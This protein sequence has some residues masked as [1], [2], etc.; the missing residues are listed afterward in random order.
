MDFSD[1]IPK[2]GDKQNLSFNDL[3]PVERNM[4]MSAPTSPADAPDT[5]RAQVDRERAE[6][7]FNNPAL[8]ERQKMGIARRMMQ[9]LSQGTTDEAIAAL[10]TPL[11]MIKRGTLNPIKG[12]EYAKAQEDAALDE[13]RNRQGILGTVS[14][15]G[16][17][18]AGGVGIASAIQRAP[19]AASAAGRFAQTLL[20]G[21]R[22]SGNVGSRVGTGIASGATYGGLSGF[23][24]GRGIED[25]LTQAAQGAAIGGV[26][27]GG[28][29][30]IAEVA[31]PTLGFVSASI[32]PKGF[33]QRQLARGIS[34]SGKDA[35]DIIREVAEARQ[36]GQPYAV[37]DAMGKAG[38]KQ[39]SVVV[40]N[41]GEGS[42]MA[43]NFLDARQGAQG[44]RLQSFIAE[45]LDASQTAQQSQAAQTAARKAD[46]RVNYGAAR[47]S[48]GAVDPTRAIAAAD[49][50]LQPGVTGMMSPK[51]NI[52]DDSVEALVGRA[53]GYLTDGNSVKTN[54]N[55]ALR[56]KREIDRM[57]KKNP[58]V[59]E[60]YPIREALDDALAAASK[61]YANARNIYR[62]Q[63]EAIKALD[64]GRTLAT[65]GRSE[66]TIPRFQAM[67]DA[68]KASARIGYADP[69]IETIQRQRMGVNK[70]SDF[71][72]M[73][74]N[75]ELRAF[76][77]PGRADQLMSRIGREDTMFGT[78][79][80]AM[81]GSQ[82]KDNFSDDAAMA[83]DPE[84]FANIVGGRWVKAAQNFIARGADNVG[85]NTPK[86]REEMARYLL[87]TGNAQN[88]PA[89]LA[90]AIATKV[91][92]DEIANRIL[93]GAYAGTGSATSQAQPRTK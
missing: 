80:R 28:L 4:A 32:D 17:G 66:D 1:L 7:L 93:R 15:L 82:T 50:F 34:E 88:L 29:Q 24:E 91:K 52:A 23:T 70:A 35:R 55:A 69:L 37:A 2:R 20:G 30:G 42:T 43:T 85:G 73:G 86:V 72:A 76:A 11:E 87:M 25:R 60:L 89:D 53:K 59:I 92:R 56:S 74:V 75:D 84:V 14:E 12:Y 8:F 47:G 41:P 5:I 57:I 67:T 18:V 79:A 71:T 63:S 90:K 49:D 78:R 9:G 36:A 81:G 38:Q 62:E 77:A 44:R 65:R 83:V 45:G 46:A 13:A 33:A 10:S 31:K 54:F 19:A 40:R 64:T 6:T 21:L 27:G 16:G 68:E 3:L 48:A 22:G 61:P 58:D 39:L 26:L 51:A